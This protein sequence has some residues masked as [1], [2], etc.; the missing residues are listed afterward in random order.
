MIREPAGG[1]SSLLSRID[2]IISS[3]LALAFLIT[4][5]QT[6][7][8]L[9]QGAGPALRPIE[10]SMRGEDPLH[11]PEAALETPVPARGPL[12]V[13]GGTEPFNV[14]IMGLDQ[15]PGSGLPGRADV[16]MMARIDPLQESVVLL[17]IPRDLW[18][19][20]PGRGEN[21]VNSAYFY[22]EFD[23]APGGGPELM[24]RT[25]EHNFDVA[26]DYYGTL[27]FECFKRIIDILGG[28]TVEV[29]EDIRDDLYPDDNYGYMRIFIPAGRQHMDGETALQYVRARHQTNDFSRMRRQQQVLLAVREKALRLDIILSLPELVPVLGKA[30][31]TDLDVQ[32]LLALANLGAQVDP[33]SIEMYVVDESLTIPYVSP[34]GAQVLLPRME[35]IRALLDRAFDGE[36]PVVETLSSGQTEVQVV[37]RADASRPGLALAA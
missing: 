35:Q 10:W 7:Y 14:L 21:R 12:P 18:V 4:G 22:G 30:F 19:E 11:P 25:I 6:G 3:I 5:F 28:I 32:R 37:V 9:T 15:R 1:C 24:K 29:P 33:E 26:I 2:R 16:I 36:S 23:G 31:S 13:W 20:I 8:R 34:D 17:S 27:D